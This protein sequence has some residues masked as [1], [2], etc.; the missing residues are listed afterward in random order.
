MVDINELVTAFGMIFCHK[1]Y[2]KRTLANLSQLEE[3]TLNHNNNEME[4]RRVLFCYRMSS[5]R[6]NSRVYS[7]LQRLPP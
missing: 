7:F 6:P 3:L 1:N 4:T 2:V 5:S